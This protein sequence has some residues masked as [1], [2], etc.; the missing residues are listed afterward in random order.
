MIFF[1]ID[2]TLVDHA[3]AERKAA[4]R[5]GKSMGLDVDVE[6]SFLHRWQQA[7]ERYLKLYFQ[8]AITFEEQRCLRLQ[9][10]FCRSLTAKEA[11]RLFAVYLSEYE[12]NWRLYDDVTSCLERLDTRLGIITN[13]NLAQQTKKLVNTSIIHYF[14]EI[15]A[16][17]DV[18]ASKPEA[19]IF[20]A[21]KRKSQV[22]NQ[23]CIY[24][25]DRLEV[26]AL[27]AAQA[28]W[29]GIWLNRLSEE[30]QVLSGIQVITSLDELFT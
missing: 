17:E 7:S 4:I 30:S 2:G 16:S 23:S 6:E 15:V 8:R 29:S 1:D 3:G 26:D 21:A 5:F 12:E 13:G 9:E 18:G 22:N 20:E 28:G 19:A 27:G 24:V 14:D 25:G 11:S 10:I